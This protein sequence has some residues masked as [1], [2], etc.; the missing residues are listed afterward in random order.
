MAKLQRRINVVK[1]ITLNSNDIILKYASISNYSV[2][3][4]YASTPKYKINACYTG[5]SFSSMTVGLF[6]YLYDD[7]SFLKH[8][9]SVNNKGAN[10]HL[11]QRRNRNL[12]MTDVIK[13]YSNNNS[14]K[15]FDEWKNIYVVRNPISRFISGFIQIC[16]LKI[17]LPSNHPYCFNCKRSMNCFLTKLYSRLLKFKG[18]H[19]IID[20]FISYHFHPQKWQCEYFKYK[21][22]YKI[23]HY[24]S[25]KKKF[26][27]TYL[28]ELRDSGVPEAKLTFIKK[29]FYTTK[30]I[31]I[32]DGKHITNMYRN[33]LLKNLKLLKLLLKIFY[34]D[35]EEFKFQI[36][37]IA[38]LS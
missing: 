27:E 32:T 10:R 8:Y 5:K 7:K 23:I 33:Y 2:R 21:N 13:K 38:K 17:G 24:D 16:V 25:D 26:Y 35:F 29:L 34:E 18:T 11:C 12:F 1:E 19:N 6:C 20:R 22:K 9:K 15:F 30:P 28:E 36:P 31:H 3:S 14:T 37:N 4:E